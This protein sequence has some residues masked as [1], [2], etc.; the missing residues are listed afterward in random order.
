MGVTKEQV[1]ASLTLKLNPVHLEVIDTS[2]GCGA[3][4]VV[5]IV[6]EQFE[7]KRLLER[8]R[9]VNAALEEEMKEIHALSIKKAQTPQQWKPVSQDSATTPST[10]A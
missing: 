10:E 6:S 7:G 3:S 8:H 5:E 2:G 9:I 4:F 1:E